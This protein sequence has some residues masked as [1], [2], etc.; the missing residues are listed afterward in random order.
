MILFNWMNQRE[1]PFIQR[2]RN[3]DERILGRDIFE[4]LAELLPSEAIELGDI[5]RRFDA[6]SPRSW[7]CPR[8]FISHRMVDFGYAERIAWLAS[9]HGWDYW[10]DVHDPGLVAINSLSLSP[11]SQALAVA[12]IIEVALLNCTH[13]IA[14][15]TDDSPGSAWIPYEYGRVKP[16][17]V[18]SRLASCWIHAFQAITPAEYMNLGPIFRDERSIRHWL[19]TEKSRFVGCLRSESDYHGDKTNPPDELPE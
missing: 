7:Q 9:K 8:I 18:A 3:L 10:L 2:Y 12:L 4:D 15:I 11:K 16:K 1:Q 6:I 17:S 13:V 14:T 5:I 19:L